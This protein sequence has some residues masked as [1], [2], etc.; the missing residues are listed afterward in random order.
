MGFGLVIGLIEHLQIIT[1]S[2]C[3]NLTNPCLYQSLPSN[4]SQQ[5]PMLLCLRRYHVAVVLPILS[6]PLTGDD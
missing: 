1:A 2:N 4:R 3:N 6:W 5:H